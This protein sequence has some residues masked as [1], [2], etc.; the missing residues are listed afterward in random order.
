M[1]VTCGRNRKGIRL[2]QNVFP[3][4]IYGNK[5]MC[6]PT[7][8]GVY[9][10][11][12]S[13]GS[14]SN[15]GCV[16]DGQMTEGKQEMSAPP[17]RTSNLT[18]VERGR[19]GMGIAPRNHRLSTACTACSTVHT[20]RNSRDSN[21]SSRDGESGYLCVLRQ[22]EQSKK[23]AAFRQNAKYCLCVVQED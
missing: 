6:A 17:G 10:R 15:E 14:V 5:V 11:S 20:L 12:R 9:I 13:G 22:R 19:V 3:Y 2:Q 21:N 7:V 23:C 4:V 1:V 18:R 16:V 8:G